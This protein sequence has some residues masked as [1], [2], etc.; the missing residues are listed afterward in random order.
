[1]QQFS[2]FDSKFV[3]P[4]H[5]LLFQND[6]AP[7]GVIMKT[8]RFFSG[9]PFCFAALRVKLSAVKALGCGIPSFFERA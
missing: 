5:P 8:A 9:E 7:W 1:M 4:T 6:S 2:E 3:G